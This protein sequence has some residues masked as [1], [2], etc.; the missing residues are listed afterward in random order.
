MTKGKESNCPILSRWLASK[1]SWS[2]LI[3]SS[4]KRVKKI[5]S[6]KTPSSNPSRFYAL[7]FQ[8]MNHVTKKATIQ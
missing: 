6:K 1:S 4:M 7:P 3:N 5:I 8:Y 2:F